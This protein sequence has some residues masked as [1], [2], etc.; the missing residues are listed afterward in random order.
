[1]R[2]IL[3]SCTTITNVNRDTMLPGQETS[4]TVARTLEQLQHVYAHEY[5]ESTLLVVAKRSLLMASRA[6]VLPAFA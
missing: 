2:G 5:T 6:V 1:M 3:V 4:A